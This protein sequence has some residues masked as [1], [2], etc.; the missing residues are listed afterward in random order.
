MIATFASSG[1]FGAI[2]FVSVKRGLAF[3]D[4]LAS[5]GT[6]DITHRGPSDK[7]LTPFE[8]LD[9]GIIAALPVLNL[10]FQNQ[11]PPKGFIFFQYGIIICQKYKTAREISTKSNPLPGECIFNNATDSIC[12]SLDAPSEDQD[13][14][15]AAYE[16]FARYYPYRKEI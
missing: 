14:G 9:A 8:N 2:Y 5:S 1:L 12:L 3:L 15:D 16:L 11:E 6:I 7:S 4:E 13:A 10:A